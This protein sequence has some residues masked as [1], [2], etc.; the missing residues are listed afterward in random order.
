M[1]DMQHAANVAAELLGAIEEDTDADLRELAA[2]DPEEAAEELL[3]RAKWHDHDATTKHGDGKR[4]TRE[5][6]A[7]HRALAENLRNYAAQLRARSEA[8]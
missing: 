3:Y 8:A 1:V 7:E 5:V 6:R 4:S 2:R